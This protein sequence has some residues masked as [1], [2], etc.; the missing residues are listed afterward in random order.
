MGVIYCLTSPSGKQYIGQTKRP[1]EKRLK[2][3]CSNC[4]G[5]IILKAAIDKYGLNTFNVEI[6]LQVN[7]TLLN[8]YE[9]KFIEVYNTM[10]PNGYNVRSGGSQ[11]S[12]HSIESRQ[13]MRESKLGNKNHNFGKERSKET[14]QKISEA[15][16]GKKHHFYGK[17]LSESH[18]LK[19]SNSH[20]KESTM[21]IYMVYVKPRPKQYQC[22]GY[23]IVNH[24]NLKNKYFTSKTLNLDEKYKLALEYL[25]SYTMDAVQRL[26]GN[27]CSV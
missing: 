19:L 13:R 21:P 1:I 14:K 22:E 3:H 7:N 27:G 9:S 20:K 23:A 11:Q 26:N 18:K 16:S 2:E 10:E 5:S 17:S 4:S 6:L 25:Q 8:D 24:P 12:T 15:R